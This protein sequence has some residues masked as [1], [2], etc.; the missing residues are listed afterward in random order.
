MVSFSPIILLFDWFVPC[1]PLPFSPSPAFFWII[2]DAW[3]A[4]LL[5]VCL[6]LRAWSWDQI[7]H[8]A[9]CEESASPSAYVSDSLTVFLMNKKVNKILKKKNS[10]HLLILRFNFI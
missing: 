1:F 4:Q 3:V 5:S 6:Q 2:R 10:S 8:Q 9:P 7:P